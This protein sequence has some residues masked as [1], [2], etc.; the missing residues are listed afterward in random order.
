MALEIPEASVIILARGL[1]IPVPMPVHIEGDAIVQLKLWAVLMTFYLSVGAVNSTALFV[2]QRCSRTSRL[3]AIGGVVGWLWL[4][5]GIVFE[6]VPVFDLEIY[7][8]YCRA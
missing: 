7:G 8:W 3:I 1:D 6:L 4:W 2:L 5:P